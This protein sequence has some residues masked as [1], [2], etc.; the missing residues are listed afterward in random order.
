M[1]FRDRAISVYYG[2]GI[3]KNQK[4]G[5]VYRMI[6]RH[7]SNFREI[8]YGKISPNILYRSN[9]PICNGKQV[10]D[11]IFSINNANIK[12]VINLS[13]STQSLKGKIIYCPW[14][15]RVFEDNNV[16][17]LNINM[18]FDF[19]ERKFNEKLK[20][21][22]LFMIEHGPPYLIHCEVGIDRTGFLAVILESIMGAPFDVIVKDYM[23]SFVDNLEYSLNDYKNG[24]IFIINLFS[25]I[26]GE[27][28]DKN[29]NIQYL[30]KKYLLEKVKLDNDELEALISKFRNLEKA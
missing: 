27:L 5:Y 7:S 10:K 15:K 20:K 13:D 22:Q 6:I 11:I 18:K 21:G 28:I 14:Y 25:K 24:E 3:D 26:K 8:N 16:I 1:A 30:T 17:A 4:K 2:Y 9:H 19:M 23:L 12:T 29:E